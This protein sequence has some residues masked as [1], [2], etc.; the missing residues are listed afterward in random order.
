MD[1]LD[2]KDSVG[3][4]KG[5]VVGRWA[6][7]ALRESMFLR[8]GTRR[9]LGK[10]ASRRGPV[11]QGLVE[12]SLVLP[13][14]LLVLLGIVEFGRAMLIY[15]EVTSASREAARYG[16]GV[17]LTNR[18]DLTPPYAD[19]A[20]IIAAA[21]RM[22]VI[23]PLNTISISYDNPDPLKAY[24]Y[25]GCPP[26]SVSLGDRIIVRVTATYRPIVPLVNIPPLP[27]SS[28]AS[29]T[30]LRDIWIEQ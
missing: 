28:E 18:A 20:G 3:L 14:L 5:P 19:C 22:T 21:R 2:A 4:K 27:I 1:P 12:F 7:G 11:G 8:E 15:S 29:R 10:G 23:V 26:P 30:I 17:G 6:V 16:A 13:V 25:N 24:V 9:R